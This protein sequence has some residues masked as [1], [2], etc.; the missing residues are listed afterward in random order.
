MGAASSTY[1]FGKEDGLK[2]YQNIK[3]MVAIQPL[4]YPDFITALG[5]DNFIGRRV[6]KR[7]NERTGI[8]LNAV[9]FIPNVKDITVPTLLVQNSN[10]EYLNRGT[11]EKYYEELR[12]EKEMMWLDLGNKRAAAY[13]YLTRNPDELLGFFDKYLHQRS[14]V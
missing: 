1:A 14:A 5:L 13:D 4:I 6:T 9:S 8:D 12:V 7:N 3:A 10:D 11:I 2:K